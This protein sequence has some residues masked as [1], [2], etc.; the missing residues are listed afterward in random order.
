MTT[1]GWRALRS[2]LPLVSVSAMLTLQGRKRIKLRTSPRP[3]IALE[4]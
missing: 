2:L 1:W 3:V 4:T